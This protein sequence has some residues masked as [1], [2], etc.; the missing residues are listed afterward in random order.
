MEGCRA[1]WG[2]G[3]LA[4]VVAFKSGVP[5]PCAAAVVF[6]FCAHRVEQP[7]MARAGRE[8][9]EGLATADPLTLHPRP[10]ELGLRIED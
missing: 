3:R 4:G 7:H 8:W 5:A 2:V 10:R 9:T 1:G 6:G